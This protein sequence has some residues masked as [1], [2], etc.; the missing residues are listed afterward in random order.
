[1]KKTIFTNCILT[2]V[3]INILISFCFILTGCSLDED[4]TSKAEKEIEYIEQRIAAM[5]NS[6]NQISF[7]N[8]ILTEEK[9]KN[10]N[11]SQEKT[12]EK[13][14]NGSSQS[15]ESNNNSNDSKSSSENEEN[16]KYELRNSGILTNNDK[17]I[18]W[19][20][21]KSNTE[22]LYSIWPNTLIDLNQLNINSEELLKFSNVLDEVTISVTNEDKIATINNF[23]SLYAFLSNYRSK[24][25]KDNRK[26]N[27][28]LTITCVLNSYALAEQD[29]WDSIS[30]QLDN[31]TNYFLNV[32]NEVTESNHNQTHITRSYVLL[33]ELK[34]SVQNRNKELFYIKYRNAMEELI[35]I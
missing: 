26:I 10:L 29:K 13:S 17:E 35:Y 31:A 24:I 4:I 22:I 19:E 15:S 3:I 23:A 11:T 30:E 8:S 21:I 25:S 18:N 27:I 32:M 2:I 14:N 20:Y 12:E 7:A 9:V 16:I 28:D 1:M 6:L 34:N 5:M 33:N